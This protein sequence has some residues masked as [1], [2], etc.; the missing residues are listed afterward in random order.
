MSKAPDLI[1]EFYRS[2]PGAPR[3]I[4]SLEV[5]TFHNWVPVP[6]VGLHASGRHILE[7]G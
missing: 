1:A 5:A 2:H 4:C 6:L 3:R 7:G